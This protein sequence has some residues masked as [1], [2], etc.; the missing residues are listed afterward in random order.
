MHEIDLNS[1]SELLRALFKFPTMA[2]CRIQDKNG[3]SEDQSFNFRATTF[4]LKYT[5]ASSLGITVD[6]GLV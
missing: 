1:W 6:R 2:A 3:Q 5:V 4:L